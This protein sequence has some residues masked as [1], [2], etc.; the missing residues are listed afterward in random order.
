MTKFEVEGLTLEVFK[1]DEMLA[2]YTNVFNIHFKVQEMYGVNLY[3]GNFDHLK[4]LLCPAELAQNKA[5]QNRHQ[6]DI[7]VFDLEAILERVLDFGGEMIGAISE[8]ND[9]KS[10]GIYDPDQN[11]MVLKEWQ[12]SN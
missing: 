11:S 3:A 5:K 4:L 2:F 10:V 7:I 9:F 8:T 12:E 6:F 1:M